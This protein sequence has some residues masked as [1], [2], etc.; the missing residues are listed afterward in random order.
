MMPFHRSC[1]G[2]PRRF[3][4]AEMA[5]PYHGL[6]PADMGEF[7]ETPRRETGDAAGPGGLSPLS[8]PARLRR[9]W[10]AVEDGPAG[11]LIGALALVALA[12]AGLWLTEVWR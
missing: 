1:R 8:V 10:R 3:T 12:W 6:M 11:A 4:A 7:T 9:F 5:D 2:C